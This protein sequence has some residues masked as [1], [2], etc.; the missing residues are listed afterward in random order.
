MII[1]A[2]RWYDPVAVQRVRQESEGDVLRFRPR[3]WH[4][5][6]WL[7][8]TR[9]RLEWAQWRVW[10]ALLS[11]AERDAGADH[12]PQEVPHA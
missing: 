5:A 7:M 9:F 4:P 10:R 8:T 6:W 2:G 11:W 1:P 12:K 3:R